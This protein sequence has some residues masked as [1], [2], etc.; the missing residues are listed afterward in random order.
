[1]V[2]FVISPSLYLASIKLG[3]PDLQMVLQASLVATK[4]TGGIGKDK[5][6]V[7]GVSPQRSSSEVR[8]GRSQFQDTC[9]GAFGGQ[10][11]LWDESKT[12]DQNALIF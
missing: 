2:P 10:F 1:M 5:G 11:R 7:S 8:L 9:H 3:C 6:S 12:A 4:G